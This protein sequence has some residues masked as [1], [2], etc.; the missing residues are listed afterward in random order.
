M[1]FMMNGA[2]TIGTMD[3]AN[4]E[5]HE[6]VGDDNF[7][8]FG[9][10]VD[11]VLDFYA[12]GGYNS[13]DVYAADERLRQVIDQLTSGFFTTA[14]RYEFDNIRRSLLDYDDEF[15]VLKDFDSYVTAQKQIDAVYRDKRKWL[16]MSAMNIA[17]SGAFSSDN[18]I[19]QYASDIWK[20]SPVI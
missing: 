8:S 12:N 13:W 17:H 2:V 14:P 20:V 1:K 4:I 10:S 7:V 6:L 11:Q 18:T 19:S 9:L 3:G 5:I 15:F 16:S